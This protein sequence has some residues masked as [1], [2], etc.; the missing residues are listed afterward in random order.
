MGVG[1]FCLLADNGAVKPTTVPGEG[2]RLDQSVAW[3][4]PTLLRVLLYA[5]T[6]RLLS[7]RQM[8]WRCITADRSGQWGP[9]YD[10]TATHLLRIRRLRGRATCNRAS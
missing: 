3:H 2:W 7:L 6:I 4:W 10:L 9:P 1:W 8:Q 5:D